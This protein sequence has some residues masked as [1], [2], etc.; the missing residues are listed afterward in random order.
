L[1]IG[2]VG[3]T[4]RLHTPDAA[5]L[6]MLAERYEG[7]P[8]VENSSDYEFE[9][10]LTPPPALA[11]DEDVRVWWEGGRWNL[12]RGDFR[13]IWDPVTRR[14]RIRQSPNPYS[15]D[16]VLRIVRAS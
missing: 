16:T 15:V 8:G 2:I 11:S 13:A 3:I 7:F 9:V 12:T 14:G 6:Q 5:S 4:V 1:A 10:D